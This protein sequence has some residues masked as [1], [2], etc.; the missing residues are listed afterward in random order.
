MNVR[1]SNAAALAR[2]HRPRCGRGASESLFPK[3]CPVK[4]V[5]AVEAFHL[6]PYDAERNTRRGMPGDVCEVLIRHR[7]DVDRLGGLGIVATVPWSPGG[8]TPQRQKILGREMHTQRL[9]LLRSAHQ[10]DTE[11]S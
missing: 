8:S 2:F 11:P 7:L 9:E 4:S 6:F 10:V 5:V 1:P 3:S